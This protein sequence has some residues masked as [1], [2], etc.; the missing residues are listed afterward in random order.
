MKDI[1]N[2]S[3][4]KLIGKL[5]AYGNMEGLS[6][7]ELARQIGLTP[8]YLTSIVRGERD[9]RNLPISNIR[10]IAL[11][12]GIPCLSALVLAGCLNSDDLVNQPT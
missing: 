2:A 4:N 8:T 11:I 9:I 1:Q 7:E 12:L 10:K 6:D 3:T 5:L